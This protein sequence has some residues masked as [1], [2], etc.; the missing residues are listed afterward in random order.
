MT[1]VITNAAQIADVFAARRKRWDAARQTGLRRIVAAA[2]EEIGKRAAGGS[3]S[4]D[5]PIP[6]RSGFLRRSTGSKVGQAEALVFNSARYA[7]AMQEGY[8]PYGNKRAAKMPPR[9]FFDDGIAAV[10]SAEIMAVA[11]ARRLL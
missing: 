9:R 11:I 2:E 10:D 6:V 3:A 5:Y 4:G 7:R 8:H 1:G